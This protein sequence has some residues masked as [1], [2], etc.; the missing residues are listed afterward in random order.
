[1]LSILAV[2][3]HRTVPRERLVGTYRVDYGYGAER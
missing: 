1:M 3:C 2:G